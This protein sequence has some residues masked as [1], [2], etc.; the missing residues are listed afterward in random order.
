MNIRTRLTLRFIIITAIIILVGSI[1][2][3]I[4]SANHREDDFYTRLQSKGNNT[5]KLLIEVDEV[6][7]HLLRKIERDNPVSM[8]NEKISIFN[9]FDTILYSTDE[10]DFLQVDHELLKRIR[11][12]KELRY[13]KGE[14]EVLGFVFKGSGDDVV[15]LAAATDTYGKKK[16][17]YLLVILI[18]VF[19]F[20]I[21]VASI[22][23]WFFAGKALQPIAKVVNQVS[24]IS[25]TSL[26]RRVD[27]GNGKDEVAKLAQTFNSMLDRLENSFHIQKNFIGNASHEIRTP[28]TAITGQLEVTLLNSRTPEEYEKVI[29]SVLDDIRNLNNLSNR[30]LLLAQTSADDQKIRLSPLRVDELMWQTKEE[31]L[32]RNPDYNININFDES[33]DDEKKLTISGD[34]QLV[35]IALANVIENGCKYSENRTTNV[36]IQSSN[37]NLSLTF[38]DNGIGIPNEDLS[39]IFEPF[40]RGSNTKDTKGNGIG[41]SMVKGIIKLHRGTIRLSSQSGIG[42]IITMSIPVSKTI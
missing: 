2:I 24:E 35:K 26:N 13:K 25:I 8:P 42:T 18:S 1:L 15:V 14:Y 21:V 19:A 39:N 40:Y 31:L 7:L 9:R 37:S 41:L 34:E 3:Y 23:G 29:H 4:F 10:K 28:L 20:S 36:L 5:A 38:K 33:L 17:R 27:E 32:K 30:L 12:A 16:V 6:D 11:Q 22:S